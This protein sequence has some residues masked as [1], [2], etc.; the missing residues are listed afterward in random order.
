MVVAGHLHTNKFCAQRESDVIDSSDYQLPCDMLS[1]TF[2]QA[3]TTIQ[4]DVRQ[5]DL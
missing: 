3:W 2:F 5:H 1:R 4:D